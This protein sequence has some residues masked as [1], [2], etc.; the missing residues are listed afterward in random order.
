M[1]VKKFMSIVVVDAA[2]QKHSSASLG[3]R[4]EHSPF[5]HSSAD[6]KIAIL[7]GD[8]DVFENCIGHRRFWEEGNEPQPEQVAGSFCGEDRLRILAYVTRVLQRTNARLQ[9]AGEDFLYSGPPVRGVQ[10]AW[11]L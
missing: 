6:S 4:F 8:Y 7:L 1:F 5:E 9:L 2:F 11:A 3:L 10:S